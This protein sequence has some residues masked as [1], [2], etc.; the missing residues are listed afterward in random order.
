M[1]ISSVIWGILPASSHTPKGV[2][3]LIQ[4]YMCRTGRRMLMSIS[5]MLC[6]LSDGAP[7]EKAYHYTLLSAPVWHAN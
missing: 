4:G 2:I 1:E 7:E 6:V 3:L 5:V